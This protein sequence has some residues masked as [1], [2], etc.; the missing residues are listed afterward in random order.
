LRAFAGEVNVYEQLKSRLIL[1]LQKPRDLRP[2]TERQLASHLA[3]HNSDLAAF[4]LCAADLL[5]EYELVVVF[6]PTFTPTLD[7]RAELADLLFHCRPSAHELARAINDVRAELSQVPVRLPDASVAKLT[8]HEVMVERFVRLLRLE[9]GPEPVTAAS[10]RDALSADLWKLGIALL[11]DPGMTPPHQKCFAALINHMA[12]RRAVSREL[13]ETAAEFIASQKNL[14]RAQLIASAEA[15][16][17]A[18][19]G[20]A[21]YAAGG[22]AYWSPDV[23]QH[24]HY[25]GEGKIDHQR[26]DQRH[27]EVDRVAALV[28]D[29]RTFEFSAT[30]AS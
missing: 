21:A 4:L 8:L 24:H 15:L 22:H 7:E 20:T 27:A 13:L 19:Q 9:H 17:R 3:E 26:L 18:T 30:E 12:S 16:M 25:R 23:A 1:L 6:G 28:D 14:E 10:L 5:E 2:Q 29:L 11:C